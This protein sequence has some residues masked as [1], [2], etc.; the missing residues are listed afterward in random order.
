MWF[1][2]FENTLF[3][4]ILHK[5]QK[6]KNL[7]FLKGQVLGFLWNHFWDPQSPLFQKVLTLF[8]T[9]FMR[10]RPPFCRSVITNCIVAPKIYRRTQC[11][12]YLHIWRTDIQLSFYTFCAK[13]NWVELFKNTWEKAASFSGLFVSLAHI[14]YYIFK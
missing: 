13:F 7:S 10:V 3:W 6:L 14:S 11:F 1:L 2:K 9:Q 8:K 4:V 12:T 5:K